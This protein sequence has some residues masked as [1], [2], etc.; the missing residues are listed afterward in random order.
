MGLAGA[1]ACEGGWLRRGVSGPALRDEWLAGAR[2]CEG[3]WLR[4]GM[5]ALALRD[6]YGHFAPREIAPRAASTARAKP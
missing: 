2:A 1:R 6:S 3:G 4:R 5:S